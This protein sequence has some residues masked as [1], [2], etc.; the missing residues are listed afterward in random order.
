V[1]FSAHV[2]GHG[3]EFFEKLVSN[4]LEAPSPRRAV[5]L[6]SGAG[7]IGQNQV[8]AAPGF[9]IIGFT[10]PSGSPVIYGRLLLGTRKKGQ[11]LYAGK[12]GTGFSEASLKELHDALSVGRLKRRRSKNL[13][14][15]P[16]RARHL[17]EARAR[18]RDRFTELTQD[19]LLRTPRSKVWRRQT[20]AGGGDGDGK[21]HRNRAGARLPDHAS[22]K[23]L[24]PEQGITKQQLLV[25]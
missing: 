13:C 22:D 25:Y 23:L 2:V 18:G 15:A 17:G 9:S 12:V 5:A 21:A 6:R 24:Y 14:A 16:T 7:V 4:G 10:E 3:P 11:L 1:R 8:R 19:G 20:R